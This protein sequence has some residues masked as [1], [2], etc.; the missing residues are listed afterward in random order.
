[1]AGHLGRAEAGEQFPRNGARVIGGRKSQK[2]TKRNRAPGGTDGRSATVSFVTRK[3]NA[4]GEKKRSRS[5]KHGN[6]LLAGWV[7]DIK[8]GEWIVENPA[9]T[10]IGVK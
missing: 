3:I 2:R 9:P 10:R 1:M 5:R 6:H 7:D 8:E 4:V